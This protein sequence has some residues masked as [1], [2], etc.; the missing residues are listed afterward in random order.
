MDFNSNPDQRSASVST[1]PKNNFLNNS[2]FPFFTNYFLPKI[3]KFPF[4]FPPE[5]HSK[6]ANFPGNSQELNDK[7][8]NSISSNFF[9]NAISF[10]TS[11]Q[12]PKFPNGRKFPSKWKRWLNVLVHLEAR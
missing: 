5:F 3:S 9:P 7:R 2:K 8:N 12:R 1:P 10:Q 4:I 6:L 11:F